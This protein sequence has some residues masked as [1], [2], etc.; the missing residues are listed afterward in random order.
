MTG[1]ERLL[2]GGFMT[3]EPGT[4]FTDRIGI[5]LSIFFVY[6]IIARFGLSTQ[7]GAALPTLLWLP[8]GIALA[9]FL[10]FGHRV[11]P[12]IATATF[13]VFLSVGMPF[14]AALGIAFGNV[15]GP[16]AGALLVK[17]YSDFHPSIFRIRDNM[18]IVASALLVPIVTA[19]IALVSLQITGATLPGTGTE[20][21]SI[22]WV[23][24]AMSILVFAP[25]ILTWF[26]RPFFE[27]T[28]LQQGELILVVVSV[29]LA[30]LHIFW[31]TQ[32][33]YDDYLF[34]PL[35][36]AALR[37]GPRGIA[38]SILIASSIALSGT[39]LGHG[40]FA[41]V[42]LL[43]LQ[44][45]MATV[46]GVFLVIAAIV[47]ERR[48]ALETL[49]EHVR[50]LEIALHKIS[51]E[52][53]AKKEF[54]AVLA[55]E[56]RNPLAT[57][58]SS[59]ELIHM[60]VLSLPKNLAQLLETINERAKTMVHLLDD[61]L[62]IS[63]ISQKK[64]KLRKETVLVDRFIDTLVLTIQPLM[65]RYG[66]TFSVTRPDQ[67]LFLNADPTRLE[68]IFVN[69]LTNAAKYT[70]PPGFIEIIAGHED[71]MAIIHIRDTGMGIPRNMLRRIFE[72]FFQINQ[73]QLG[74]EGLGVGLALTRQ[75][76]EMHGGTIEVASAGTNSGSEFIVR[77]PLSA[78][79][80]SQDSP[81][82]DRAVVLRS[83][84]RPSRRVKG[85]LK[86]LIVDDNEGA[87]K[88]LAR[89]LELR[90]HVTEYVLTGSEALDKALQFEPEVILLDIGLPDIDGYEV[91]KLL[92]EQKKPYY[93]IALT[94]YGQAEDKE[95][96][97][98]AGFHYH[99]TKPAGLK[100]IEAVLRKVPHAATQKL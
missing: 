38:L 27:R 93:L 84:S 14:V 4:Q 65:R 34:I 41:N 24:D 28:P 43:Y 72:P 18:G 95:R 58:L 6:L 17:R 64:L 50:E 54:L 51:S 19:T 85:A 7:T 13:L 57:I 29:S 46:S 83:R 87:T 32:P 9:S 62:D 36:W 81:A 42:G 67:E 59:I 23:G 79:P 73:G 16:L 30:S 39:L 61:L 45:F 3:N 35:T 82:R 100:D 44:A 80:V 33:L 66:H 68:Q 55:H 63:R 11:W 2:P 56:L 21:W 99:I 74:S 98:Q 1:R 97:K 12:A 47:E 22:W 25:F 75:L 92:Q 71:D 78:T 10:L 76:V 96:A 89:L 8:S 70:K 20:T 15:V 53:E 26:N 94:G 77:L 69:L 40:P 31:R 88:A 60:E 91:A 48:L 90:G 49:G 5:L 86:I 37:T 52:D